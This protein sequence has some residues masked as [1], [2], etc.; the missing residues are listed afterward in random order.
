[1]FSRGRIV[2]GGLTVGHIRVRRC[3]AATG[4]AMHAQQQVAVKATDIATTL[5]CHLQAHGITGDVLQDEITASSPEIEAVG[6]P[7]PQALIDIAQAQACAPVIGT[8]H[9]GPASAM[10]ATLEKF[11]TLMLAANR[12]THVLAT[13]DVLENLSEESRALAMHP[14]GTL[15]L[16]A[17][18]R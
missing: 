17:T 4:A 11:V 3:A 14:L 13:A 2:S 15:G 6:M 5:T 7:P 9:P 16:L 10:M 18:K 1:M 8:T 12:R